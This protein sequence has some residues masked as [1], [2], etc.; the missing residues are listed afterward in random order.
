MA[1]A[2]GIP[3]RSGGGYRPLR[4]SPGFASAKICTASIVDIES[5]PSFMVAR[6]TRFRETTVDLRTI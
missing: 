5:V 6:K 1:P 4:S 3:S 2:A